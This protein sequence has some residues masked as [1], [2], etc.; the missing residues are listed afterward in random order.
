MSKLTA[1]D[2]LRHRLDCERTRRPAET[3]KE[4]ARELVQLAQLDKRLVKTFSEK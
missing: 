4:Q 3:I 1:Y 2:R